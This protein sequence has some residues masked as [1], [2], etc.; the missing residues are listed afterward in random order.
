[1]PTAT[2]LGNEADLRD[3]SNIIS[4]PGAQNQSDQ[5]IAGPMNR[6]ERGVGIEHA[7][8]GK[9][10]D[11]VQKANGTGIGAVLVVNL[12]INV[13]AIR[14]SDDTGRRLV[15][16]LGP[17]ANEH[18]LRHRRR[19]D[20]RGARPVQLQGEKQPPVALEPCGHEGSR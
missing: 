8:A 13:H 6:Y 5:R 9:A 15:I 2:V 17:A 12:G 1:D 18:L 10:N 14:G 3:V 19:Y 11:V 7:A 16:L 20:L 4:Y